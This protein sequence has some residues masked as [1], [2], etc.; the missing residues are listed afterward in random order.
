MTTFIKKKYFKILNNG[1][2]KLAL[3]IEN[4]NDVVIEMSHNGLHQNWYYDSVK[5]NVINLLNKK[6]LDYFNDALIIS[7]PNDKLSQKWVIQNGKIKSL[8][9]NKYL[10]YNAQKKDLYLFE[11]KDLSVQKWTLHY[12]NVDVNLLNEIE[13]KNHNKEISLYNESKLKKKTVKIGEKT[14]IIKVPL[15]KQPKIRDILSIQ[16]WIRIKSFKKSETF[17]PI[18]FL[19]NKIGLWLYPHVS[20]LFVHNDFNI[21]YKIEFNEWFNVVQIYNYKLNLLRFFIN[22]KLLYSVKI[23]DITKDKKLGTI[24]P[25]IFTIMNDDLIRVGTV[26]LSNYEID[27]TLIMERY[28]NSTYNEANNIYKYEM[29]ELKKKN[30]KLQESYDL[31][32]H[33]KCPPEKKCIDDKENYILKT[34]AEKK[35][36]ELLKKL[37]EEE[38]KCNIKNSNELLTMKHKLIN[39]ENQINELKHQLSICN[40]KFEKCNSNFI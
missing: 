10:T 15:N 4:D 28:N 35:Y 2:N 21:D 23:E 17:K 38:Q 36:D 14:E 33:T 11:E 3:S 40:V 16:A 18:Y 25:N 8:L 1:D 6:V 32:K 31:L 30:R 12:V 26:Y 20:K 39:Y 24:E 27:N 5:N 34:V 13:I 19:N 22:G 9:T 7:E 29:E 37:K